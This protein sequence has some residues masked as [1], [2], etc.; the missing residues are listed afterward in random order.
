MVTGPTRTT[1]SAPSACRPRRLDLGHQ[2]GQATV[3]GHQIGDLFGDQTPAQAS[4]LVTRT[5][6][7]QQLLG[8]GRRE[9][10]GSAAGNEIDQVTVDAAHRLGAQGHQLVEMILP[11]PRQRP[12]LRVKE[13]A[14]LLDISLAVAYDAVHR[15]ELPVIRIG[16]RIL[17]P[18]A[19][20][21][22]MVGLKSSEPL[23]TEDSP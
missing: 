9:G 5:H 21:M 4:H 1:S 11:D 14:A 3:D 22:A 17:V 6:L 19:V 10:T 20:L 8:L 13:A 18:T 12:T 16:R 2:L 15:G 23:T 7:G